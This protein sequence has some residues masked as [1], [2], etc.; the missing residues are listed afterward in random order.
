MTHS[1]ITAKWFDTLSHEKRDRLFAWMRSTE[2]RALS[3]GKQALEHSP[4][5]GEIAVGAAFFDYFL[6]SEGMEQFLSG[7]RRG[8]TPEQA[9]ERAKQWS[10]D[11]VNAHN[12]KRPKDVCWRRWE[13]SGQ[14]NLDSLHTSCLRALE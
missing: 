6:R 14:A 8:Y 9:L 10:E 12:A 13:K 4:R 2:E 1:A 11:A 3:W 7:L 5:S